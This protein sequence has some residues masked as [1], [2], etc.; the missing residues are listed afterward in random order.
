M[1][2]EVLDGGHAN[3]DFIL[4]GGESAAARMARSG[5]ARC[6]VNALRTCVTFCATMLP[7]GLKSNS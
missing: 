7:W 3:P 5:N 4:P 2:H 6:A 1:P